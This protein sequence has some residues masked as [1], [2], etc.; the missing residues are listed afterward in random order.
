MQTTPENICNKTKEF[1][2]YGIGIALNFLHVIENVN[3]RI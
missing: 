3:I 2:N 1:C